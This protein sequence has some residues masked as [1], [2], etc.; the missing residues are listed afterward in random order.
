MLA[1]RGSFEL[2]A[3][4]RRLVTILLALLTDTTARV[5]VSQFFPASRLRSCLVRIKSSRVS[6]LLLVFTALR[7]SLQLLGGLI[8][9]VMLMVMKVLVVILVVRRLEQGLEPMVIVCLILGG[10]RCLP[11]V[12]GC[13]VDEGVFVDASPL[14]EQRVAHAGW[15]RRE[16]NWQG[17]ERARL[18]LLL[19]MTLGQQ[20]D[21]SSVILGGNQALSLDLLGC[22]GFGGRGGRTRI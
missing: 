13:Q 6:L 9:L 15:V 18:L 5:L 10:H 11:L 20:L 14:V 3:D 8:V 2:L 21:A 17:L 16:A 12:V 22:L 19:L 7:A 4:S 1:T